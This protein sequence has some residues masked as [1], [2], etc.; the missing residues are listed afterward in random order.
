MIKIS[1]D[2]TAK[3]MAVYITVMIFFSRLYIPAGATISKI[4]YLF[5]LFFWFV[6]R[7]N[8]YLS[9][10]ARGYMRAYCVLVI[11]TIPSIIF[12]ADPWKGTEAFFSMWIWQYVAFIGIVAFIRRRSSLVNMLTAFML[13]TTIDCFVALV[14][15]I[16]HRIPQNRGWGF[17]DCLLTIA[18]VMCMLMPIVLV[19]LMD[20]RFEKRLKNSAALAVI[21]MIVG[22]LSNKSR[23]A[24][25]TELIVVPISAFRYLKQNRKYLIIFCLVVLG[26]VGY[27]ATNPQLVQRVYSIANTTTDHS[28]ADRIWSWKSAKLMVRDYP[29]TGVGLGQ[30]YTNYVEGYKYEEESQ[31]LPHTHNNFIEIAVETGLIGFIGL[32]Y[33]V[34]YYLYTSWHNYCQNHNPYDLLIFTIFLGHICVFGQID[35]TLWHWAGMQ[36]IMWYLMAILLQLKRTEEPTT[37]A[38]KQ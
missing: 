33:F 26:T 36:P 4:I 2:T 17:G 34:G 29:I 13:F 32:L 8:I 35:Y 27:M 11:L 1:E 16:Y 38:S 21:G 31:T 19:I 10:E 22:L 28:N 25:L 7:N 30:F 12:S 20:S 3:V 6:C 9:K 24:W 23:G 14:Q 15:V 5:I 18:D 37:N